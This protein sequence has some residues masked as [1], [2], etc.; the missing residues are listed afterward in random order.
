MDVLLNTPMGILNAN[1]VKETS[2][3]RKK[4]EVSFVFFSA[5]VVERAQATHQR[6]GALLFELFLLAKHVV[7][8]S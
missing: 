3:K 8:L 6:L 7:S 4:V 5:Y 2:I 1:R